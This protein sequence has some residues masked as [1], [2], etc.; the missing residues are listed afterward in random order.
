MS[1]AQ[2]HPTGP[3]GAGS[4]KPK[5]PV[6]HWVVLGSCSLIALLVGLAMAG[7]LAFQILNRGNP[8]DTLDNLYS[9][10][11]TSDCEQFEQNT[12]EEFRDAIQMTDCA[13]F[14][15]ATANMVE[16]D[17][18]VNERINRQGYAIF[19][20]T[21]TFQREGQNLEAQ[22]RFYVRRFDGGW[23]LDDLE[24]VQPPASD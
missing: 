21:E 16:L 5:R 9:A 17:Y 6:W 24:V 4:A 11:A 7:Y 20:V 19:E 12:T 2:P 3:P 1:F 18:E 13:V 22:M 23:Y 14:E 15:Q 8:Q 10:M